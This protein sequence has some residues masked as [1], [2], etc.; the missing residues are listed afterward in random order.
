MLILNIEQ[1]YS[2]LRPYNSITDCIID[3]RDSTIEDRLLLREVLLNNHQ[4]YTEESFS[5]IWSNWNEYIDGYCH[6]YS[7]TWNITDVT[8][9][10]SLQGFMHRYQK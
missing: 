5:D 6:N 4:S 9:N 10:I 1:D 2:H 8:S 3:L 7:G